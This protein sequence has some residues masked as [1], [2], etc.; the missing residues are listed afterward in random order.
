MMRLPRPLLAVLALAV[1]SVSLG[2][3]A[4]VGYGL[5]AAPATATHPARAGGIAG[6]AGTGTGNGLSTPAA[7]TAGTS[8]VP[9]GGPT[10][11]QAV[12]SAAPARTPIATWPLVA[13][14]AVGP[15]FRFAVRVPVLMYHR[16][17]P[18]DQVGD[19]LPNLVVRPELFAAQ[20]EALVAAGWRSITAAELAADLAAGIRPP[21]RTFVITFD[22]GRSDGYTEAFPIL[23]RLGL[24]A[25]FYVVT[26][27][28]GV[29]N[30]L[31]ASQLQGLASAGMEIGS[32]S[33]DHIPLTSANP[34]AARLQLTRS[35]AQIAAV[36]GQ[37]PTTFAYPFG[38]M[39]PFDQKLVRE[40]GYAMA[41]TVV[42]GCRM[43][44]PT[45]LAAPRVRVSPG[46]SPRD[47]LQELE[48][49]TAGG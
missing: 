38:G 1:F 6:G 49:C 35:A 24:V 19:S 21:R 23:R 46:T 11:S 44:W 27:R 3:G 2:A 32:H 45:R 28:I 18:A 10:A 4:A 26:G 7:A 34:R 36:T 9:A 15:P 22:D 13:A 37:R 48:A 47:L 5:A 16:V 40:T 39:D 43:S 31:S 25:T 33:V 30:S 20:L 14:D 42:D 41:F 8:D 29:T 17:A 12:P